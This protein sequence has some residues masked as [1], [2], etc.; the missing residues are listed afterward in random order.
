MGQTR[1]QRLAQCHDLVPTRASADCS[2][3]ARKTTVHQLLSEYEVWLQYARRLDLQRQLCPLF[4]KC[5]HHRVHVYFQHACCVPDAA[6]IECHLDDSFLDARFMRPMGI[7]ELKTT[8]TGFT[9]VPLMAI[10]TESFTSNLV[11]VATVAARNSD[12]YHTIK[13]KSPYLGHDRIFINTFKA[14][15]IDKPETP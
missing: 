15:S 1:K 11:L 4:F 3:F 13:T 10:G 9:F 12:G 7:V 6:A 14:F 5:T 2:F 8:G